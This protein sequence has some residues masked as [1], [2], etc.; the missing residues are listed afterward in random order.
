MPPVS[1]DFGEPIPVFPLPQCIL[2]PHTAAPLHIFEPRYRRMT[3][4]ALT[5][6]KLIAMAVFE[7]D[8]WKTEYQG[9]P[10][11]RPHVCIGVIAKHEELEDGRFNLLLTG[12]ARATIGMEV[13]NL[14]FRAAILRP[15]DTEPVMEIDLAAQRLSLESLLND[16]H[17]SELSVVAAIN[18]WRS[19]DTPTSALVDQI[20]LSMCEDNEQKYRFLA[21]E[22]PVR[23]AQWLEVFLR[24][25]RRSLVI[26]DR[27]RP[28]P[29]DHYV[30]LN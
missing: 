28:P 10:P 12:V 15:V 8:D 9:N 18:H 24:D 13:P 17:L 14:H 5:S 29:T 30:S 20:A 4:H 2:F 26:A 11:I 1:I 21:E 6:R 22:S 23:R 16:E 3:M 27:F 19:S 7:G 25:T